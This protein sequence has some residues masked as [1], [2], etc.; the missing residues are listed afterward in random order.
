MTFIETSGLWQLYTFSAV[1]ILASL[2]MYGIF[3]D[4]CQL[5]TGKSLC[6]AGAETLASRLVAISFLYVGASFLVLTYINKTNPPKL[7]R[8]V[9]MGM[10]CTVAMI[11]SI[12]FFGPR[13][14]GGLE[15]SV[16][17]FLDMI[18]GFLLLGIMISAIADDS[19]MVG[20]K[21]PFKELGMNPKTFIFLAF[22]LTFMKLLALSDFV[23]ISNILE[24][25]ETGTAL[26]HVMYQWIVVL[27]LMV[28]F[29][30]V[31]ALSYGDKQDQ[32]I[33]AYTI[34]VLMLVSLVSL[35]P[36][37]DDLKSGTMLNE[38]IAVSIVT[39]FA[40]TTIYVGRFN[41]GRDE[42]EPVS[43]VSTNA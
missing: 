9:N 40:L 30:L 8:L 15:S 19:Q 31:F 28:L 20:S 24:D 14:L 5:M 21:S 37:A 43:N 11:V 36:I 12:I 23:D 17:H 10:N 35:I 39:L 7:K 34:V 13:S 4:P 2:F 33:L 25:P 42:Y 16:L 27:I 29:P 18:T 6:E 1:N 41:Q 38:Y 26:S 3:I 22:L 32:E